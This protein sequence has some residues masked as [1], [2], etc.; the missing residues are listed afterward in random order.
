MAQVEYDI[1][2]E[3]RNLV[4]KAVNP[5]VTNFSDDD[6]YYFFHTV[7]N[8]FD[9]ETFPDQPS[10]PVVTAVSETEKGFASVSEAI[11]PPVPDEPYYEWLYVEKTYYV[12]PLYEEGDLI[13]YLTYDN[14]ADAVAD[15]TDGVTIV[16]LSG[17][18]TIDEEIEITHEIVIDFRA[19]AVVNCQVPYSLG[20]KVFRALNHNV[21]ILGQGVFNLLTNVPLLYVDGSSGQGNLIFTRFEFHQ[22]VTT[23]PTIWTIVRGNYCI[24]GNFVKCRLESAHGITAI[25][26]TNLLGV[27]EGVV[28]NP[29]LCEIAYID[30]DNT[31]FDAEDHYSSVT[32]IRNTHVVLSSP[33]AINVSGVYEGDDSN[34]QY[35]VDC[36]FNQQT[37]LSGADGT[38]TELAHS[39]MINCATYIKNSSSFS[40]HEESGDK[41]VSLGCISNRPVD[42]TVAGVVSTLEIDANFTIT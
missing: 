14:I 38:V 5:E 9:F 13:Q 28:C 35:F 30:T 26:Y 34:T 19:G 7:L 1:V 21:T 42:T 17:T 12:N 36:I 32:I 24:T 15:A 2:E 29:S 33:A 23:T 8:T 11:Q 16:V 18:H 31:F 41:H 27:S 22:I 6:V 20:A 40:V 3:F 4:S 10:V 39:F 25:L 37:D